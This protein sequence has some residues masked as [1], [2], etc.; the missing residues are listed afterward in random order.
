MKKITLILSM[1][2]LTVMASA[3]I[4]LDE[5]F[6]GMIDRTDLTG[7][8]SGGWYNWASNTV[9]TTDN[10]TTVSPALSYSD[11]GGL[12]ALSG[13]GNCVYNNYTG[14]SGYNYITYKPFS[15]NPVTSGKIYMSFL[16]QAIKQGGSQGEIIGLTDSIQRNSLRCWIGKGADATKYMLGLTR[17][18]G[19]AADILYSSRVM[20]YGTT[21][22]VVYK[23]DFATTTASFFVNPT[24]GSTTEGTPDITDN[25]KGTART[26]LQYVMMR[27]GGSNKAYYYA[28]SLRIC[29]SWTE[30]VA[31]Y[32]SELPK[33]ATPTVGT[34]SNIDVESFVANWTK[35]SNSSGYTVFVYN[36]TDLFSKVEVADPNASSVQISGLVSNTNYSYEVQAKGDNVTNVNSITSAMSAPVTTLEG[37]LSLN[38]DFSDGSW[39][40]IYPKSTD[41]PLTGSFPTFTTPTGYT[42]ISGLCSGSSKTGMNGEVHVN[43]IK[44]DKSST[45]ACLILP[46]MKAVQ[47][48][49]IHAWTGTALRTFALQEMLPTGLWSNGQT[50]TTGVVA[51]ADTVFVTTLNHP[52]GTKLRIVNTGSGAVNIGQVK[53]DAVYSG[54]SENKDYKSLYNAGRTIISTKPGMITVYNL[55]G[56]ELLKTFIESKINTSLNS[57]IYI[58]RFKASDG[59]MFCRKLIIQ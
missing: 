6:Q 34:A 50:F 7:N 2:V 53:V 9:A 31:A 28:S 43:S 4:L 42:V 41:E 44:L 19:T 40:T 47:R 32:V 16:F 49:E 25:S 21:Y 55:Q 11:A 18:S 5:T 37:A 15:A 29:S 27:N 45:G 59:T 3:Q 48:V 26:A 8:P 58:A 35:V 22:L 33:V 38:P 30:A 10:R 46:S 36:G 39:G 57:G 20:T 13:V 1:C 56:V 23:Y 14:V 12:L 51:N 24:V 52:N 54:L 17:S